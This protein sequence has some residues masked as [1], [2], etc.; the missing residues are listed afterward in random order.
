MPDV[1][2]LEYPLLYRAIRSKW[3]IAQRS[4]G[5]RLR[6]NEIGL[7]VILSAKCTKYVCD[8]EQNTC[9]GEFVLETLAVIKVGDGSNKTLQI[10]LKSWAFLMSY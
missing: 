9:F 3:W 6:L 1:S 8:A 10:M 7:S 2:P 4:A 5:F